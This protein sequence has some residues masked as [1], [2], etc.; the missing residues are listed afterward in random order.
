MDDERYHSDTDISHVQH[1]GAVSVS[2]SADAARTQVLRQ[3]LA[4]RDFVGSDRL[5]DVEAALALGTSALGGELVAAQ[6]VLACERHTR[7]CFFLRRNDAGQAE[8]FIAL[9]YLNDAGYQALMY[10]RFRPEAPALEFLAKPGEQAAA[11]YVW[12]LAG[13]TD[14]AKRAVVR[15]VTEA[16]RQAFPDIALFARPMSREGR[17]MT[18]ALDA[19]GAG[20]AWLG[21]VPARP[22]SDLNLDGDH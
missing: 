5:D 12:C 18:A 8:G 22:S 19:P 21:W 11:I 7:R 4:K 9:L 17:M 2:A 14:E 20:A 13:G 3:V 6:T 15:A 16:R 1:S 10:G